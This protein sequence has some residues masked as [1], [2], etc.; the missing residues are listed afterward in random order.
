MIQLD[1]DLKL[2][3]GSYVGIIDSNGRLELPELKTF[4]QSVGLGEPRTCQ[5][6]IVDDIII[7]K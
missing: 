5:V 1:N 2:P 4:V 6:S 3:N 7:I